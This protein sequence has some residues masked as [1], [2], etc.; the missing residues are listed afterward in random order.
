MNV[1]KSI[2]EQFLK[3]IRKQRQMLNN[4]Y[5]DKKAKLSQKKSHE[6]MYKYCRTGIKNKEIIYEKI[7]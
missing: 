3:N 7:Y 2:I 6:N 4:S 1:K 5:Y